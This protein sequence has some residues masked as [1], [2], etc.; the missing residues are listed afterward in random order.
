MSDGLSISER[1]IAARE[2]RHRARRQVA[3]LRQAVEKPKP[4]DPWCTAGGPGEWGRGDSQEPSEPREGFLER[5]MEALS[6]GS[7]RRFEMLARKADQL[8][9]W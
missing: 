8:F 9:R 4:I 6:F 5:A 3:E 7:N 2:A 1:A